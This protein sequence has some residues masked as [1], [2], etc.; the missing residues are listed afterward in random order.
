M[1]SPYKPPSAAFTDTT[2][3]SANLPPSNTAGMRWIGAAVFAVL[4]ALIFLL[5]HGPDVTEQ[6]PAITLR[7][8][9]EFT[10]RLPAVGIASATGYLL[11]VRFVRSSKLG[12]LLMGMAVG[13]LWTTIHLVMV[14]LSMYNASRLGDMKHSF[15]LAPF[16]VVVLI[17]PF[18][19][20]MSL[21]VR[22]FSRRLLK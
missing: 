20:M 8:L 10:S 15:T 12:A 17:A 19:G 1:T 21:L 11:A 18:T 2:P 9:S 16:I 6:D 22:Q 4:P 13:V 7:S 3:N 14:N 5:I